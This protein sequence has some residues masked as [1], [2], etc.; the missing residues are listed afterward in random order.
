VTATLPEAIHIGEL[1]ERSNQP[2]VVLR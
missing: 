1:V 2:S